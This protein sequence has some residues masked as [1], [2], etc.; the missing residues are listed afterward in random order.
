[1]NVNDLVEGAMIPT[2]ITSRPSKIPLTIEWSEDLLGRNEEA[3]RM[4]LAGVEVPLYEVGI[5]L[6]ENNEEGPIKF[7]IFSESWPAASAEYEVKFNADGVE[8]TSMGTVEP[9]IKTG[10]NKRPL[11]EYMQEEPPVIRFHDGA[12]LIYNELFDAP[13]G[14]A[15]FNSANIQ[16]WHWTNVD[17]KKESQQQ[18]KRADSIQRSVIEKLLAAGNGEQFDIV[19]DD[20][21]SGEA[22]DIVAI[23]A[24]Q[25]RL[26]V[27]LYHCKFSKE[28]YPGARV[29]DL[30][31]VCGQA[32]S[33]VYWKGQVESL[34]DHLLHREAKRI[35]RG[36]VSRFE[37][38]DNKTLKIMRRRL[39]SLKPEF[40]IHIVQPGLSKSQASTSQLEL[41]GVTELYLKETYGVTLAVVASE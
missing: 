5:E 15:A 13:A 25:D 30:Y 33:S 17:L 2:K 26:I 9:Q 28:S 34:I 38:G 19:F 8:Y 35:A 23:K 24:E 7:R 4:E 22:A 31:A 29:E 20:D 27:H 40:Q 18:E 32:Q 41:L 14:R 21:N 11:S 16:A 6:T 37:R 10:R 12:F 1:L 36:G 39:R 3:V